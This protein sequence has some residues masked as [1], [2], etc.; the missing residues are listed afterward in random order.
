MAIYPTLFVFYLRQ[1]SPWFGLGNHGIYA[2]LFVVATCAILNLAGIRVVGITSQ[3]LF[4]LLSAPFAVIVV[5]APLKIGALTEAHAAPAATGLGLL[6]GGLVAMWN[7]MGWDNAS[8]IAQEVERPQR[9]YRKAM[10]AAVVLVPLTDVR[11]FVAVCLA[12]V[13]ARMFEDAGAVA[14]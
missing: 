6:G 1:M 11:P 13:A 9:T 5:M 7:Y 4:F 2:G 12:G 10:I 3:W 8:T 14:K